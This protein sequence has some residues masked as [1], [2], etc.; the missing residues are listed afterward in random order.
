M[1]KTNN[2]TINMKINQYTSN[3]LTCGSCV[4]FFLKKTRIIKLRLESGGSGT[5]HRRLG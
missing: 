2:F 4:F 3:N 5:A 1:E